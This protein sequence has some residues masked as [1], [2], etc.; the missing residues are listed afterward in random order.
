MGGKGVFFIDKKTSLSEIEEM[1]KKC[2]NDD[3]VVQKVLSQSKVLSTINAS[4]INTIRLLTLLR[5]NGTVKIC[6]IVLRMGVGGSKVDNASSGGIVVGVD[7]DGRLKDVAYNVKGE[8]FFEHPDSHIKF[9]D[10]FIPNFDKIKQIVR[11]QAVNLPYF[12]LV[13][14]DIAIDEN[15]EPVLIEANLCRGELDFH[16]LTNGPVFGDDTE[17]ILNEVFN[18]K[19]LK[20]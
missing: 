15:N 1:V 20:K 5:R 9:N 6:S 8:R 10:F 16:Q 18:D 2:I 3:I 12:R 7:E 13:S 4:S 17:E 19:L 11:E 14:W